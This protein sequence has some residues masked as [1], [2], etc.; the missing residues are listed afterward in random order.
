MLEY[1]IGY[2]SEQ[3]H[4]VETDIPANTADLIRQLDTIVDVPLRARQN[5]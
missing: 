4:V 1:D 3:V 2:A 5:A